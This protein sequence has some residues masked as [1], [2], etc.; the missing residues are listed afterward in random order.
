MEEET[1]DKEKIESKDSSEAPKP[2]SPPT[3]IELMSNI[4]KNLEELKPTGK[5]KKWKLP[6]KARVGKSKAKKNW[7]GT[8]MINENSTLDMCKLPIDEGVIQKDGV[9]HLATTDYIMYW[10]N[11]PVLIVPKWSI[12]PI[13]P[14]KIYEDSVRNKTLSAGF[15]LI[16][17]FLEKGQLDNKKKMG[18]APIIILGILAAVGYFLYKSGAFG[19]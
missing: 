7:V 11:K 5:I 8:I 4:N 10:K 17:N 18:L 9:P 2:Q 16:A 1:K 19:G 13:S 3:L 12:E 6:F 15:K 14:R